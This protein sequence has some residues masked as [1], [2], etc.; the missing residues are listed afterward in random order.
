[1]A[2]IPALRAAVKNRASSAS[3]W[4]RFDS[5]LRH[6]RPWPEVPLVR[7]RLASLIGVRYSH[8]S[9]LRSVR[10]V[11]RPQCEKKRERHHVNQRSHMLDFSSHS[12]QGRCCGEVNKWLMHLGTQLAQS[13]WG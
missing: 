9:A 10:L 2:V 4:L 13:H 8:N 1:M 12:C 7:Q 5:Q 11:V 6:S 3:E